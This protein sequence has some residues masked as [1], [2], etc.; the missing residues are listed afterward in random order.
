MTERG[1]RWA[2]GYIVVA[3]LMVGVLW[4]TLRD[5]SIGDIDPLSAVIATVSLAFGVASAVL[6]RRAWRWQETDV[7]A[8]LPRL[9]AAV[10]G[11]EGQVRQ[12]LLGGSDK[13]I[14]V[15]FVFVRAAAHNAAQAGPKG[16]LRDVVSYYDKLRPRRLVITGEPGSGKTVLAVELILSL[17]ESRTPD[18]P[19]PVRLSAS[20]LDVNAGELVDP[21]LA[22][23]RVERWL[24]AH[25]VNTYGLPVASARELV[26]AQKVR[27]VIDGLDEMDAG[28]APGFSSRAGVTLQI[29]NAYQQHRTKAELVITCRSEQ[30]KALTAAHVQVQD[31][32]RVEINPVSAA[33]AHAFITGRVADL[34]RWD[35]VLRAVKRP[36]TPLEQGLSTPW[37]LTLAVTVYEQ[38]DL[39]GAFIRHPDR[40][41]GPALNTSD[42]VRDHLLELFIPA[43]AALGASPTATRHRPSA[44]EVHR[45]LGVLA[46][47]LNDNAINNRSLGG[48]ALSSTD[49]VLHELWP[50]VGMRRTRAVCLG[51]FAVLW[52]IATP[53]L[54][55]LNGIGFTPDQLLGAG[56]VALTAL[57]GAYL[58]WVTVWPE[59]SHIDFDQ[60]RTGKGLRK[61]AS[62]L[63]L[64]L[65]IGPIAGLVVWFA[66]RL[67]FGPAEGFASWLVIGLVTGLMAGLM[68]G[69]AARSTTVARD[70]RSI[71]RNDLLVGL[72]FGLA[73]GLVTGLALG[74]VL[75]LGVGLVLG[76]VTAL[77]LGLIQVLPGL[78][79]YRYIA[80]LLCTRR[81]SS[82]WLPWRFGRS[83]DWCY[84]SGL[85]RIAGTSYQFRHREFQ[86]YLARHPVP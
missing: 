79:G 34:D 82:S 49:I 67:V 30:Y 13:P 43:A 41:T 86:D 27:P 36:G 76:L 1:R 46:T 42:I 53:L 55:A 73:F 57:T 65:A 68:A 17:L 9:A 38:R 14:D 56:S 22:G 33:K 21:L 58:C 71:V 70:P 29:L 8:L 37:R 62:F 78:V 45:W 28:K 35:A 10:A 12:Q 3:M 6:A 47:Y 75:G 15:D 44:D 72:A 54:L 85:L 51:M 83:L 69:P 52:L 19:V 59:P 20:S 18:D 81:R 63:A 50:L 84:H 4:W 32:A 2:S 66:S 26:A 77:S 24:T 23:E 48:R 11:S 39:E 5:N 40:L 25:L 31:A 74:L 16:R 80:L 61:I 7:A 64:G 60:L